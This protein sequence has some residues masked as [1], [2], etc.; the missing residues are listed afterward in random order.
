MPFTPTFLNW[1]IITVTLLLIEGFSR[2]YLFYFW[3]VAAGITA[4]ITIIFPHFSTEQQFYIFFVL[5]IIASIL[6]VIYRW[7]IKRP[8][9]A[10]KLQLYIHGKHLIGRQCMLCSP[11]K[12]RRGRI[13]IDGRRWPVIGEDMPEGT[14]VTITGVRHLKLE[15]KRVE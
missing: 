2:R 11:I 8:S 7:Y 5:I 15:V 3:S 13:V 14:I 10:F 1:I 4:V 12:N 6:W 9:N